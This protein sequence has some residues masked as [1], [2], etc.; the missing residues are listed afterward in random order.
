MCGIILP[1]GFDRSLIFQLPRVEVEQN[2]RFISGT[3]SVYHEGSSRGIRYLGG[4]GRRGSRERIEPFTGY[5]MEI[6]M[7]VQDI[8][9]SDRPSQTPNPCFLTAF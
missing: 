5:D 7:K 8:I 9:E 6:Y 3:L 2:H 1:T 4:G